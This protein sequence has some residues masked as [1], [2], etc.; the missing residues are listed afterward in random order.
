MVLA[1]T[2]PP[3]SYL[4]ASELLELYSS[5]Y[6]SIHNMSVSYMDAIEEIIPDPNNPNALDNVV[7]YERVERIEEGDK[8][9]IRYSTHPDGFERPDEIMEHAF[10]GTVTMDCFP[11][12]KTGMIVRGR[13]QRNVEHMNTLSEYMLLTRVNFRPGSIMQK[14]YPNGARVID[15]KVSP[16]GKVRPHLERISGEWCHV[17]ETHWPGHLKHGSTI[18][19]TAEKGGLPLKYEEFDSRGKCWG[20]MIVQK[21]AATDTQIGRVWYPQEATRI[22]DIRGG[23][24]KYRFTCHE[25][26]VNVETSEDTWKFSFPVGTRVVD[27]VKGVGYVIGSGGTLEGEHLIIGTQPVHE[28]T[29]VSQKQIGLIA[30]M[31]CLS[32]LI[33]CG[34]GIFLWKRKARRF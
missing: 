14:Y 12:V 11:R 26:R 4:S 3:A 33:A 22:Q 6:S 7:R 20:S 24:L 27:Y 28:K 34:G 18:W 32:V 15:Q 13:T 2:E 9:H 10:N 23:T 1:D 8:Y 30:V 16:L 17:V 19:L 25:L 31:L 21:I 5:M 29:D